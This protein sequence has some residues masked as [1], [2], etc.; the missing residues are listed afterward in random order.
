MMIEELLRERIDLGENE[1]AEFKREFGATSA[2][3]PS[4]IAFANGLFEGWV[5]FG[6]TDRGKIVG[7]TDALRMEEQLRRMCQ[8]QCNPPLDVI[9]ETVAI[10]TVDVLVLRVKGAK[11]AKPYRQ[12]ERET[13][14]IRRGG[15]NEVVNAAE[16]RAFVEQNYQVFSPALHT[17][18]VAGFR[19]LYD[20]TMNL[21]PLNIIIGPNASGKSNVFKALSFVRDLVREGIGASHQEIGRNL[22]WYGV[23]EESETRFTLD[24][25]MAIP[26][27]RGRFDPHYEVEIQWEGERP[28]IAKENLKL[29]LEPAGPKVEFINRNRGMIDRYAERIE[30]SEGRKAVSPEYVP[31]KGKLPLRIAALATYGRES[32]FAPLQKLYEF[33]LGWRFLRVDPNAARASVIP[34]GADGEIPALQD[35]AGNLSAFLYALQNHDE[36]DYLWDEIQERLGHAI[37]SPQAVEV[38]QRSSLMGGVGKV[39]MTFSEHFFPEQ[40]IPAESMS[41]G[42]ISLLATL[43]GLIGD[44]DA[45][46]LCLEEPDQGLHPHL[47]GRLADAIRS[48]VDLEPEPGD[49][50]FRCPQVIITTHSPDFMDCF[51]LRAE[52]DYLQVFIAR[53]DAEGKTFFEPITA[54]EFEPWLD[55]YRLGS[56][57]RKNILDQGVF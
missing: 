21:K 57:A 16:A 4:V 49:E 27:Q 48:V 35:D 7:V 54:E 31:V 34:S 36:F 28:A 33:I 30:D 37:Q 47:M 39:E 51:D 32:T 8:Q 5:I 13:Y 52:R 9:I 10:D 17:L 29:R 40:S 56:L 53:R 20:M 25:T 11:D 55:Q 3:L 2:V 26:E 44:P 12:K 15:R 18:H 22:F 1:W 23:P 19:S 14:W 24:L 42:T 43:A 6:V 46:L 50:E 38:I 41:D 45:T